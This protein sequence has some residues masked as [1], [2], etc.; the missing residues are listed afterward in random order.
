VWVRLDALT[1]LTLAIDS[2]RLHAGVKGGGQT[3]SPC[4]EAPVPAGHWAMISLPQ[5]APPPSL[6][7]SPLRSWDALVL[8][9]DSSC[10]LHRNQVTEVGGPLAHHR[11]E[12][13]HIASYM[14]PR[15]LIKICRA[16]LRSGASGDPR[17]CSLD[18]TPH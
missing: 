7:S 10:G 17:R 12:A 18:W 9:P 16:V 4:V 8:C 6:T 3:S 1:N 11:G 15:V 14:G 13:W 5:S 2:R